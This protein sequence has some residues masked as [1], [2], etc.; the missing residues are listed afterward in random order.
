MTRF[1]TIKP[2]HADTAHK[3]A[4]RP[5]WRAIFI[6]RHIAAAQQRMK[7]LRMLRGLRTERYDSAEF[8]SVCQTWRHNDNRSALDDLRHDIASEI[9]DQKCS[10][11]RVELKAIILDWSLQT[12]PAAR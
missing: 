12:I 3:I 2:G 1:Q 8:V 7:R 6:V 9:T 10:R 4:L 5:R 11:L